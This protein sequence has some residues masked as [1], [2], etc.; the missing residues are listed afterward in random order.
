MQNFEWQTEEDEALWEP[1]S[2]PEPSPPPKR[3]R[4]IFLLV[5]VAALLAAGVAIGRQVNQ[6]VQETTEATEEDVLAADNLARLAAAEGDGELLITLLSGR[7]PEW[8]QA[9]E[10]LLQAQLLYG[11]AATPFG[12]ELQ[13]DEYVPVAVELSSDLNEALVSGEQTYTVQTPA[14]DESVTLAQTYVYR[15][16][17][18]NW[19]LSPPDDDT[20]WGGWATTTGGEATV[21]FP[22]RDEE[23]AVS[24]AADLDA[25]LTTFCADSSLECPDDWQVH[26]R[27]ETDPEALLD[28][29]DPVKMLAA[30]S[31]LELPA[32]SL[33][34]IPVDEAAYDAL[35]RGY[36]AQVLSAFIG[37]LS[38]WECCDHLL[39]YQSLVNYLL[40]DQGFR[41][42]PMSPANYTE[43][44]GIPLDDMIFREL[45]DVDSLEEA[46]EEA[47]GEVTE[48]EQN[49]V[50]GIVEFD[51]EINRNPAPLL[52]T[53]ATFITDGTNGYHTW[54]ARLDDLSD[55]VADSRWSEFVREQVLAYQETETAL[56]DFPKD[57][58]LLLF[59]TPA[60][61][62][63]AIMRY[64]PQQDSLVELASL[65]GEIAIGASV[66]GTDS[67]LYLAGDFAGE[68]ITTTLFKI[69]EPPVFVEPLQPQDISLYMGQQADPQ[70]RQVPLWV[71]N[72]D[73][74][75]EIRFSILDIT[76]CAG[77][78]SCSQVSIPGMPV[79]SASG[80]RIA[81]EEPDNMLLL[82][83]REL[84][85]W[86]SI[87]PGRSPVWLDEQTLA[88]VNIP[89][90]LIRLNNL[91]EEG[92]VTLFNAEDINEL[93]PQNRRRFTVQIQEL[94]YHPNRPDTLLFLASTR[95]SSEM[96]MFAL[97]PE[98]PGMD[99][100]TAAETGA[101]AID[102]LF[103]KRTLSYFEPNVIFSPDG[104]WLTMR[105][106]GGEV[107]LFDQDTGQT[108][109][110]ARTSEFAFMQY[111]WSTGGPWL[112]F[113]GENHIELIRPETDGS[114]FRYFYFLDGQSCYSA[115]W[116]QQ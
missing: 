91:T 25:A 8:T 47:S 75:E 94:L 74:G 113:I 60:N 66:K 101:L 3:R 105:T 102:L 23:F 59:C 11:R 49:L 104:R 6:R 103:D 108:T 109:I 46:S 58:S 106:P 50:N 107:L 53:L 2:R 70:G 37:E 64:D 19:L 61:G 87:G 12:F 42:R 56:V 54:M 1:E 99:W 95:L 7:D 5:A 55:D 32:P 38:G 34:G 68:V 86:T 18:R 15:R 93:L 10:A 57:E 45:W 44:V 63:S 16:G 30:G 26:V 84:E 76:S 21:V 48:R 20:F 92:A 77:K 41:S 71:F 40:A 90:R 69:G 65:A 31:R 36:T 39:Y 51:L 88:Y 52:E 43:L 4:W 89:S 97:R 111:S 35:A 112:A 33:V 78:E 96:F 98:E 27:L 100:F 9:H 62:N 115:T 67:L 22:L 17:R 110:L 116:V 114:L 72:N 24:F 13:P 80:S 79:W 81:L 83:D 73:N 28:L 29:S 14:G 82:G 85:S